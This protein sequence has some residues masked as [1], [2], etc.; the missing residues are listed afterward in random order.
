MCFYDCAI[1]LTLQEV[2]SRKEG[3]KILIFCVQKNPGAEFSF[4]MHAFNIIRLGYQYM[5]SE[6]KYVQSV[7]LDLDLFTTVRTINSC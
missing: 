6:I 5:S 2:T 3:F 1:S 4:A 7:I